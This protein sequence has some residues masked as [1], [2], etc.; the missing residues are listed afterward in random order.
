MQYVSHESDLDLDE[1]FELGKQIEVDDS[2][3]V[4]GELEVV[5][6]QVLHIFHREYLDG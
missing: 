6:E 2:V 3:V 1:E 5:A 4:T